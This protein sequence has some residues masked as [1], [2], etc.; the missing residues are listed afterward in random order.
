MAAYW[1]IDAA[2]ARQGP[3]EQDEFGRLI[4]ARA[5]ELVTTGAGGSGVA[6]RHLL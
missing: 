1:W 2:G 4:G 5:S 3:V 6:V